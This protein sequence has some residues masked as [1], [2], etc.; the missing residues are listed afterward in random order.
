MKNNTWCNVPEAV[1]LVTGTFKRIPKLTIFSGQWTFNVMDPD[2]LIKL[3]ITC[4]DW[5]NIFMIDVLV[6]TSL[7]QAIIKFEESVDCQEEW[8]QFHHLCF[9]ELMWCHR[10]VVPLTHLFEEIPT[11]I[12]MVFWEAAGHGDRRF[13]AGRVNPGC[14]DTFIRWTHII[15]S[16]I[17]TRASIYFSH[18]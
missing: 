12:K 1:V 2:W 6:F 16:W 13:L 11:E 17:R 14:Y 15:N 10:L 5:V 4:Y 8:R 9:W 7:F 3:S 18:A